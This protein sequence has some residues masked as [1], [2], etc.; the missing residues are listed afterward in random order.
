MCTD[1]DGFILNF[2]SRI[3]MSTK[4]PAHGG[5]D[6]K[7]VG[8]IGCNSMKTLRIHIIKECI[9]LN[10]DRLS[11]ISR[12]SYILCTFNVL[13]MTS[14]SDCTPCLGGYYCIKMGS[15]NFDFSLNDTGTGPCGAGHYCKTGLSISSASFCCMFIL[16]TYK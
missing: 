12:P 15:I 4:Q 9:S 1:L 3:W 16:K 13:G 5:A 2:K 8:M 14:E 7:R 11:K 6:C 10:F